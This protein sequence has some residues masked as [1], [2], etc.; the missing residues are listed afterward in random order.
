MIAAER[1]TVLRWDREKDI[2]VVWSAD[3]TVWTRCRRYGWA[4]DQAKRWKQGGKVVGRQWSVP[5]G[6]FSWGRK[7]RTVVSEQRRAELVEQGK[8]LAG[9]SKLSDA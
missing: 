8:R 1:E 6:E 2:V 9:L 3:P 4:E 7:R 5:L